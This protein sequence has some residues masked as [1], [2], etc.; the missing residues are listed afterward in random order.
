MAIMSIG[1][2]QE[3]HKMIF[4]EKYKKRCFWIVGNIKVLMMRFVLAW[5]MSLIPILGG[6]L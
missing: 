4:C 6:E 2:K 5:I 3:A 1:Y